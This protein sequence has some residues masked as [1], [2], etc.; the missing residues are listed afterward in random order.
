[1]NT[2]NDVWNVPK[3]SRTS[4][5][6]TSNHFCQ[7]AYDLFDRY[8]LGV[9]DEIRVVWNFEHGSN[10]GEF[11]NLACSGPFVKAFWIA[12]FALLQTRSDVNLQIAVA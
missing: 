4:N 11:L 9:D 1:M 3:D 10:S 7:L 2:V 6:L 12:P 8:A 5:Q